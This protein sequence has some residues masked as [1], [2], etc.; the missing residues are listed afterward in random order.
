MQINDAEFLEQIAGQ[1]GVPLEL[2]TL[3]WEAIL[4]NSLSYFTC[5]A[6]DDITLYP[7]LHELLTDHGPGPVAFLIEYKRDWVL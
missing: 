3:V 1:C 6:G 7:D 4:D 5:A 2:V